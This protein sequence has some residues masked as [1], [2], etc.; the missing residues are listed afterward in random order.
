MRA[1]SGRAGFAVALAGFA[2]ALAGF[3]AALADFAAALAGFLADFARPDDLDRFAAFDLLPLRAAFA[4]P[5]LDLAFDAFFAF[6][7]A[8]GFM[9]DLGCR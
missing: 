5:L 6:F 4:R 2:V 1:A 3:A 9:L 8:R 7:F